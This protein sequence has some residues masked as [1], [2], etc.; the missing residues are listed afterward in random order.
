MTGKRLSAQENDLPFRKG[1]FRAVTRLYCP[2]SLLTPG[3]WLY[4]QEY[5]FLWRASAFPGDQRPYRRESGFTGF[6]T[7]EIARLEGAKEQ[8]R[9]SDALASLFPMHGRQQDAGVLFILFS[10]R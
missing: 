7:A 9:K 5:E 8:R 6:L 4:R 2:A 1:D 3:K 10:I